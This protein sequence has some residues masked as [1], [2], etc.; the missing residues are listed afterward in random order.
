[1]TD[2][3]TLA[4]I[5]GSLAIALLLILV[6]YALMVIAYWKIFKKFG[7]PGWKGIIPVYNTYIQFKY[8]WKTIWFWIMIAVYVVSGIMQSVGDDGT[9]IN[10]VGN[11][12]GA[13]GS[14]IMIV[15]LYKLSKSF[16]HGFGWTLG[17]IF[18]NPV[19]LLMLGFGKSQYLGNPDSA[20]AS[21]IP[22]S[23]MG[24]QQDG[25]YVYAK[26]EELPEEKRDE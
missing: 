6:F 15:A 3:Q 10:T 4:I 20:A 1:M 24:A 5:F 17:L 9:A 8:T 2:E 14:L 12:I 26:P 21:D 18:I 22:V 16:G 11:Y 7:E 19:F 13:L 23:D 25:G